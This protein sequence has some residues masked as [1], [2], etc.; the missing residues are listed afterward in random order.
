[1]LSMRLYYASGACSLSPHIV[2]REAGLPIQ[3]S[4]VSF[5]P[6]GTRTTEQ[7]ED[8]FSVNAKGGYVPTLRLDDDTVLAEGPAIVQYIA[9]QAPDAHLIPEKG[10]VAYYRTIE[11]L[12]F[13]GTEIHKGFG[14]FFHETPDAE[15]AYAKAKLESRFAYAE[16]A[17]GASPYLSGSFSVADAYLYTVVRWMPKADI[18]LA[19]YPNVSAFVARMQEREGVKTALAEEGLE[20]IS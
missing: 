5:N 9:D 6:D 3:L 2:A 8:F 20:M 12:A 4:K 16:T 1:M 10:S 19:S 18:S 14:P 15:R 17:L 7:G 13:I 11:W